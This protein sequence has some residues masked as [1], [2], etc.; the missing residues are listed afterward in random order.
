MAAEAL[1]TNLIRLLDTK[2]NSL[3]NA[4][5]HH[6]RFQQLEASWRGIALLIAAKKHDQHVIIKF[7]P[8][9]F[10]A[11]TRDLT[12][13]MEFEHTL[14]FN[15]IYTAEIDLPGGQPY[16]LIIADYYFHHHVQHCQL[17]N[18]MAKIA[19][20]SLVPFISSLHPRF[21]GIDAYQDLPVPLN[22]TS[23]IK[24][25]EFQ[26]FNRLRLKDES[27]FLGLCLPRVLIRAPYDKMQHPWFTELTHQHQDYCWGNPSFFYAKM[28]IQNYQQTRWF[29]D[30]QGVHSQ[31]LE[32]GIASVLERDYFSCDKLKAWPKIATEILITDNMVREFSEVG[33]LPLQDNQLINKIVFHSSQSIQK[34]KHYSKQNAMVNAKIST[35]LNYLLCA[36]RFGHYLKVILRDKVGSFA[37]SSACEQLLQ[38][39]LLQYCAAS[40]DLSMDQR[41]RY[42]LNAANI[43]LQTL[44]GEPGKYFCVMH[45]KP[46]DQIDQ[47][48]THLKLITQVTI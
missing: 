14:L 8:L 10:A 21:L 45:L 46:H 27:R 20:A 33:L 5:I 4:I 18:V 41:A 12:R 34:V 3:C 28:V 43:K 44:A 42:P 48:D 2:I 36:C 6:E 7:L 19:A 31:H 9:S 40:S 30:T 38:Q 22:L 24:Q 37:N 25:E 1:I 29:A 11:F 35:M 17:L 16:G 15:K 39:W 23:Y 47:I 13:A 26:P 32:G